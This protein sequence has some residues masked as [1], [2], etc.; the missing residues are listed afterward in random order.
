M[1]KRTAWGIGHGFW[2]AFTLLCVQTLPEGGGVEGDVQLCRVKKY[3]FFLHFPK[4]WK[5]WRQKPQ[6][7]KVR[8][9]YKKYGV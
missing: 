4:K 3:G 7:S 8:L 6:F 5:E 1:P 9:I 2:T